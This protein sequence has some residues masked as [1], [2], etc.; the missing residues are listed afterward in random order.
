MA[1]ILII[2]FTFCLYSM[3]RG[4][5]YRKSISR[6]L[7]D[8]RNLQKANANLCKIIQDELDKVDRYENECG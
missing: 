7:K 5:E 4:V 1:L 3:F 6:L 8:N 2:L